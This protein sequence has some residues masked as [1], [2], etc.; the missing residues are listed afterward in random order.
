MIFNKILIIAI[1]MAEYSYLAS[2]Q[3]NING[4]E[5]LKK[6]E[7][8]TYAYRVVST[9]TMIVHGERIKRTMRYRSWSVGRE[10]SFTEFL[11][12]A[13]EK[14]IKMLKIDKDLW[15]YYPKVDRIVKIAG[16]LLRQSVMGSDISYEDMLEQRRLS[17]LYKV[18]QVSS[19]KF[20]D[21]DCFKLE[22]QAK[23]EGLLYFK[24]NMWIDKNL[25][26][27]KKDVLLSKS[28][29]GLKTVI[30]KEVKHID[31]RWFPVKILYKDDLKKGQGTEF[32]IEDIQLNPVIPDSKF[33]KSSLR[34]H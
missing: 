31:G 26:I 22:L 9:N 25:Y 5:I 8:N 7:E 32:I 30:V 16:H 6:L 11:E 19:E 14:G 1:F 28:G 2:G 13:R 27:P 3:E 12:P 4:M 17:E 21:V 33:T 10:K 23:A 34:K 24:R 18:I 29:K 20:E 15:T